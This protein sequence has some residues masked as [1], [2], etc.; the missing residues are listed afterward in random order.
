MARGTAK[1]T[2]SHMHVALLRAAHHPEGQN[3]R[4]AGAAGAAGRGRGAHSIAAA[5]I[6]LLVPMQYSTFSRGCVKKQCTINLEI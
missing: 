1:R 6:V 3:Q 4:G 5:C 2:M